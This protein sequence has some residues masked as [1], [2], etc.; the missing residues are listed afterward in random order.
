MLIV[1][2]QKSSVKQWRF[3]LLENIFYDQREKKVFSKFKRDLKMI[4]HENIKCINFMRI[5]Y[6]KSVYNELIFFRSDLLLKIN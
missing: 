6:E 5:F 4:F 2:M 3:N 1:E